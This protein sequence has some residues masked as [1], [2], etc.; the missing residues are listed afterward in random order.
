MPL[1]PVL[2]HPSVFGSAGGLGNALLGLGKDDDFGV[3]SGG[4]TE[5]RLKLL[6]FLKERVFNYDLVVFLFHLWE[7][8]LIS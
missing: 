6:D 5:E 3:F 2:G 4:G 7:D 8:F 1:L